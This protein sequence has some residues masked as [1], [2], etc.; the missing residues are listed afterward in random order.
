MNNY[1]T[2]PQ[3][4]FQCDHQMAHSMKKHKEHAHAALKKA[5][6]RKVRV[7]TLDDE[8]FEGVIINLDAKNVYIQIEQGDRGFYPGPYPRPRP[9]FPPYPYNPYYSNVILPLAL[10]DLL[11]VSLLW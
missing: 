1:S 11:A 3:M 5:V 10:F 8:V 9:P 6:N 2:Q 4:L 7:Q